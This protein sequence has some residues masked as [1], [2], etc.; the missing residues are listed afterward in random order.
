MLA[1]S[2]SAF[3]C[4]VGEIN[5]CS[6]CTDLQASRKL[7]QK[8]D[9]PLLKSPAGH[10]WSLQYESNNEDCIIK[11]IFAMGSSK[12]SPPMTAAFLLCLCV[13]HSIESPHTSEL[14]GL[15]LRIASGVQNAV[16]VSSSP[17]KGNVC[18]F[19]DTSMPHLGGGR[20]FLCFNK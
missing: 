17:V 3:I 18:M 10:N 9:L 5:I 12:G 2:T 1:L 19:V 4:Q 13:Q 15:L 16:W 14:R 20:T 7:C 8:Q 11:K 6:T